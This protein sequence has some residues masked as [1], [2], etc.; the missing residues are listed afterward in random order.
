M[1]DVDL[2]KMAEHTV[3]RTMNTGGI[4][5]EIISKVCYAGVPIDK[6]PKVTQGRRKL[7]GSFKMFKDDCNWLTNGNI[8]FQGTSRMLK[9]GSAGYE[10]S[11]YSIESMWKIL[12]KPRQPWEPVGWAVIPSESVILDS[13]F[14]T[15]YIWFRAHDGKYSIVNTEYFDFMT[16]ALK[17]THWEGSSNFE[18]IV[19]KCR[20]EIV[21]MVMA[22]S[23]TPPPP[24]GIVRGL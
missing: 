13:K 5:S 24:E 9:L 16:T 14:N 10:E 21:G 22:F 20:D 15:P 2:T 19:G 3:L 11:D 17:V 1:S 23:N 8:A 4:G 18:P 7:T 12:D 6:R